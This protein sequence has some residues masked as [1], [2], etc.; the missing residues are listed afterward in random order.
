[1]PEF[2]K[3]PAFFIVTQQLKTPGS[4]GGKRKLK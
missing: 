3:N 2:E 1:M 4:T